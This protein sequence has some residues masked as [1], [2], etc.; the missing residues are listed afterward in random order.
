MKET[1]V[2]AIDNQISSRAE[3]YGGQLNN[4]LKGS[5]AR[6][7]AASQEFLQQFETDV[8]ASLEKIPKSSH[9]LTKEPEV[10]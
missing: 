5:D 6:F 10:E 3:L 7:Q 4:V 1:L 9:P 8:L 2:E